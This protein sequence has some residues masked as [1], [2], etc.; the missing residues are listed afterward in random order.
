MSKD[1][2][3]GKAIITVVVL[4]LIAWFVQNGISNRPIVGYKLEDCPNEIT[5]D[6][7]ET[8]K[9]I[10][11]GLGISNSGD[12]DASVIQHFHGENIEISNK[13]KKPYTT[14]NNT[15]VYVSLTATK[16][17]TQYYFGEKFIHNLSNN[18][19]YNIVYNKHIV[20]YNYS[21]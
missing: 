4:G 7:R 14:I 19:A 20:R 1:N 8:S 12:T 17:T 10:S 15:D 13:T 18:P 2:W 6:Y 11:T 9:E 16:E 3:L 21:L 5:F